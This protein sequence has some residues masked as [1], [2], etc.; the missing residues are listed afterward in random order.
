M[1]LVWA[2]EDFRIHGQ[3]YPGFPIVLYGSMDSC[4][5][6]NEFLR[7]YLL[8]GR[9]GSRRSWASTGRALYDFFGFL[10][11]NDLA[12]D[13]PRDAGDHSLLAAYRDFCLDTVNLSRN[14]VRQRLLYVCKF[15]E[16]ALRRGWVEALPFELEARSMRG[17][18]DFLAHTDASGGKVSAR[19]VSPKKHRDI[20]KFLGKAQ[21]QA[22]LTTAHNPHHKTILRFGL[23][24]GLRRE[25]I[26]TFP[27]AYVVNLD[28]LESRQRNLVVHLD[29]RDGHG[30]RTKGMK[31]R[32]IVISRAFMR[33]LHQY[34]V[35]LR[36]ERA[37][38]S[39]REHRNLFLNQRG[40]PFAADGK[41]IER[42]VRE[43]GRRAEIK[44]YPHMLRHYL[45]FR[46]MS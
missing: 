6:V 1:E 20:P 43:I 45:P 35:Q 32:S 16:Y 36:G 23:Q 39:A 15:Y 21:I 22:L 10:E 18:S 28:R 25:E 42:I 13:S 7:H 12:W 27:L 38:L 19:N 14:T 17:R 33:D 24:T 26:A 37:S 41:R 3:P 34:A 5:P 2:T 11:A 8:R 46:T 4:V 9:I 31:P 44:V 29:P 40:E 30:I